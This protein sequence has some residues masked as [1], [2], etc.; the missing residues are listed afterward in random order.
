ML[1]GTRPVLKC[2][3]DCVKTILPNMDRNIETSHMFDGL[4]SLSL[5]FITITILLNTI[6]NT[7]SAV[8]KLYE[9]LKLNSNAHAAASSCNP[10]NWAS[11]EAQVF[12][13]SM[14]HP[15]LAAQPQPSNSRGAL[16]G[17][18]WGVERQGI[19]HK[20]CNVT[21]PISISD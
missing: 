8:P 10:V 15:P 3:L 12:N 9:P 17:V 20:Y 7:L 6:N 1:C 18:P 21:P 19:K 16:E 13:F 5:S 2:L 4:L 11:T 14:Q